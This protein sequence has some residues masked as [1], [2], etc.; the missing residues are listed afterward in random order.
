MIYGHPIQNKKAKKS[1][2][3]LGKN[4][5]PTYNSS[6]RSSPQKTTALVRK[7]FLKALQVIN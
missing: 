7:C 1:P 5:N 6:L 3:K 2:R 4:E